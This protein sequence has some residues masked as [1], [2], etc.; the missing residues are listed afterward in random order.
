MQEA[1]LLG[2]VT[3]FAVE[4]EHRFYCIIFLNKV[5]SLPLLFVLQ[6]MNGSPWI[7]FLYKCLNLHEVF[8]PVSL[9]TF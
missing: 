1:D 6:Q 5:L 9:R 8:F 4:L 3:G 7:F 2:R